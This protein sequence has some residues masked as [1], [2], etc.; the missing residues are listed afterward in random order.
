MTQR[1]ERVGVLAA[2]RP[3]PS[4]NGLYRAGGI[5]AMIATLAYVVAVG[6]EFTVPAQPTTGG[7]AIL[8]YIAAHRAEYIMQQVLWLAPSVLLVVVFLALSVATKELDKSWA[9]IA[10]VL[11]ITSWA[12][13]LAYPATGGGAPAL[14]HLSDQFTAATTDGRRAALAAAAE[15]FIAM[16]HIATVVGVLE[17]VGILLVSVVMLKG[18]FSRG[19]VFLGISTGAIGIVCEGL[20]PLVGIGYI[21]YGLLLVIWFAAVGWTLI[22]LPRKAEPAGIRHKATA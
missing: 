1:S 11:G 13:T 18:T 5:A 7:A 3:D 17:A 10:G 6:V 8:S 14:V 9:A 4:W 20:K 2:I 19:L 21:V 15:G 16:N 22:R 12:V